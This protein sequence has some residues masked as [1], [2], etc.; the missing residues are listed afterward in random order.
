MSND[1]T[2]KA[3][4]DIKRIDKWLEAHPPTPWVKWLEERYI[5]GRP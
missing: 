3:K 4:N 2:A 5:G 1:K